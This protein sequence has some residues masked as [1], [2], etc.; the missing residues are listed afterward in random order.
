MTSAAGTITGEAEYSLADE[1][2][3]YTIT[4]SSIDL[5]RLQ[6]LEGIRDLFGGRISITSSG[7]G[8]LDDPELVVE[9]RLLDGTLEGLE[10][11]EGT[12]PPS[13]Y[14][15]I[16]AGR[17]IIRGSIGDIASIEGDG[18]VG[19]NLAVDGTARITIG[20]VAR[21]LALVPRTATIPASGTAVID[22]RLGGRLTP[23]EALVVD[24]TFPTF[25]LRVS[26]QQLVPAAPLRLSL[27]NGRITFDQFELAHQD[28]AF[29]VTG[30]AEITGNRQLGVNVR[31][32][33]QAALLG[34]F[35]TDVRAD[36]RV[37]VSASVGGTFAAPAITGRADL[38]DAQVKFAGFPQL[39][40][41]INGALLFHGDRIEIQSLRA[42]LGG[43]AVVAGGFVTLAGLAP[44]RVQIALEGTDVTL[45]Y[46]EGLAITGNFSLQLNGDAERAIIQGD[47]DVTRALYSRDFDLQ[48]SIL[49]V[50]LA[51]RGITPVVAAAWQERVL[52]RITVNAPGTLAVRNN[53]A[54]VTG[55]AE[56]DV[57]GTLANPVILGLVEL[58]EGGTVT[59][60]NI[61]YRLV[62]GT[63]NFQNPFRI[64]PFF[65]VTLEGRVS[66]N[67]SE[68]ES[69]P[70]DLT[71]N[72]TGTLDRIS[73]SI[74]S[75]PPASDITLFSLLGFGNLTEPGE[76][77][78]GTTAAGVGQGLL[79]QGLVSTFGSRILPFA[80]SF[81]YDPGL[82]DTGS[83]AGPKV[84]FEKRVSNNI[85]LLV[86]YNL[87]S[88][89]SREVIEWQASR[90]W[91]VQV[92]RDEGEN[93]Y[94]A[95]GRFRRRY[96]GHW[97]WGGRGRNDDEVFP[98]ESVADAV[99]SGDVELAPL[100]PPTR[101]AAL[102]PGTIATDVNIRADGVFETQQLRELIAIEPG[103]VV[104]KRAL[105]DSIRALYATGNFRDIRVQ[106]EEAPGGVTLTFALSI[107]Y[108]IGDIDIEGAGGANLRRAER[109]MRVRIGDVLSLNAIDD[110]AVAI[111]E[112]LQQYGYVEATVDPETIFQRDL[113][114]A[115]VIFHV[116]PGPEARVADVTLEG[117]L[118]PFTE[119]QI[120]S[121]MR[122]RP[123]RAFRLPD[124][125]N[126]V[127]RIEAFLFD[128]DYRRADVE[129]VEHVYDTESNTATL[130][131]RVDVGPLVKVEV[132][133]VPRRAVRG[134]LPFRDDDEGYSE[135]A[136][137]QAAEDMV[138]A[139]QQRGY[140]N[141]TVDTES[142]L[143]NDVW[144]TTFIVDPGQRYRLTEVTFS[145]NTT[146]PDDELEGVVATGP[147]G[148]FRRLLS[149]IFR[150]PTGITREQLGEDRDAVESH[151]R[152]QGF[153]QA[154]VGT[155]VV[156]TRAE[157]TMEVDFPIVEGPQTL[158]AA[159]NIEGADEIGVDALPDL[160]LQPGDPLN[161][162]LVRED[163]VRLQTFYAERG[164]AEVQ[165]SSR[166]QVS[167]DFTSANVSYLI[168]EG[169]RIEI[170]DVIVR[171][172][173]YTDSEVVLRT[174]DLESGDPFSYT[175]ILTA[176]QN[177][178]RLGSFQ[179]ID[180]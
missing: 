48:Q 88:H 10:L 157:G 21:L 50:L 98:L 30:F 16:R 101:I 116:T 77:F 87:D 11:P 54:E 69:G 153:A 41:D 94:R 129:F 27:R 59:F 136:I 56:L 97:T 65:D 170:G 162:Q 83:S 140:Y 163:I 171:G 138:V 165:V 108:R 86:V 7:A 51:R 35:M 159:V 66:G 13:L 24:A 111:Q 168:A 166:E 106:S 1:R 63:I 133:G 5:G 132:E 126:D 123:G 23:L 62:R 28:S 47:I 29:A 2:F 130:R 68:L 72:I 96:Q 3:G 19:E 122:Q 18:S 115:D 143:E 34:L 158:V 22:L 160:A 180:V 71:I 37:E 46:Y 148:G 135:D 120:V 149:T 125:R 85:R 141:A 84:T 161:P 58:D 12:P 118:A 78:A 102:E 156:T 145:G 4:S 14:V 114:R 175:S 150:R 31:G 49:N 121:R 64:D 139:Y 20:D 173:T 142:Q 17:L 90:D 38:V 178:Y 99:G 67:V 93:E 137:E 174:A 117:D 61:D 80:D 124:A 33:V 119:A 70:I 89:K 152:L 57:T 42:T 92:T 112:E 131:Y 146:I 15:A 151:Y 43:G 110:T 164:Y 26:D 81:T 172:N 6:I 25:D 154:A 100:P 177:L 95:E 169:P 105:Q 179:R 109:R 107:H 127:G 91:T 32:T 60:Q 9:A 45:R 73:P 134:Q 75:D 8:T 52:L 40:D 176:Q 74:S 53:I 39:I 144:T 55:S 113:N 82:L 128:R 155:P 79:I 44:Q 147:S 76:G 167:D 104:T 36:G 103:E